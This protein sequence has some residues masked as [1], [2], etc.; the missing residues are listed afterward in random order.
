MPAARIQQARAQRANPALRVRASRGGL[1]VGGIDPDEI[2][3]P[4]SVTPRV[5]NTLAGK[6]ICVDAGHGGHSLGA[7]G[8]EHLEKDLCLKMC[9]ELQRE[10]EARGARVVMTRSD[11]TFVS[12]QG[13][14]VAIFSHDVATRLRI[15]GTE[16]L[17]HE[18]ETIVFRREQQQGRWLA[19]H[20]HLSPA[21]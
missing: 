12:L 10:L 17:N 16:S 6:V 8:L 13:E 5:G 4:R 7:A 21:P 18:R 3:V 11:D 9:V 1:D 19:V 20:E 15:Q 2:R 14:D